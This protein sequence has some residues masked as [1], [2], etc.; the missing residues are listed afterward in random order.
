MDL[1]KY[2]WL[3]DTQSLYFARSDVLED[4]FEGSWTKPDSQH[5]E[6]VYQNSLSAPD[7]PPG[8]REKAIDT[9]RNSRLRNRK[10]TYIN[11][12]HMNDNESMA[13][14]NIYSQR[15]HGICIQTTLLT[16]KDALPAQVMMGAV[17]YLDY[18]SDS[19]FTKERKL[20]TPFLF[21]RRSFKFEK[22]IRCILTIPEIPGVKRPYNKISDS[23]FAVNIDLRRLIQSIYIFPSSPASFSDIV[24]NIT[25]RYGFDFKVTRSSIDGDALY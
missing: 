3:L 11:C 6:S 7:M 9:L 20:V 21:K 18:S 23:G 5:R 12:W 16:L 15:N 2:V 24:K 14:W 25:R 19:F 13:M 4:K 17:E 8:V 10:E 22:E 1:A